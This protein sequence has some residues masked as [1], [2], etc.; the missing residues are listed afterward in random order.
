M[1]VAPA[2]LWRKYVAPALFHLVP[3]FLLKLLEDDAALA[4][5]ACFLLHELDDPILLRNVIAALSSS[6]HPSVPTLLS[7]LRGDTSNHL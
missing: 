5:Q 4:Y 2:Q 6:S 1:S 7:I 3:P